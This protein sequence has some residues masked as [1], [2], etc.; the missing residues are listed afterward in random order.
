MKAMHTARFSFRVLLFALVVPCVCAESPRE[1]AR[2]TTQTPLHKLNKPDQQA[3]I[4]SDLTAV[5]IYRDGLRTTLDF[6]LAHPQ[7]FPAE[8]VKDPHVLKREEREEIWSA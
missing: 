8:K 6:V 3:R 1:G 7:L 4:A 5:R 2:P